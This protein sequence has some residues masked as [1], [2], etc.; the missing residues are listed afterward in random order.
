MTPKRL[1]VV[2]PV[3]LVALACGACSESTGP[4]TTGTPSDGGALFDGSF[5]GETFV[6]QRVEAPGPGGQLVPVDLIGTDVAVDATS[7]EVSISVAVR[8]RSD[9][10]LHA[11]GFVWIRALDPGTIEVVDPDR[12]ETG[13]EPPGPAYGYDYSA[14]LGGDEVL[15]PGEVSGA[16]RW[17]FGVPE[18]APFTFAASA[19]FALEP[20]HAVIAGRIFV[21]RDRDGEADPGE[22]PYPVGIVV[23]DGPNGEHTTA[24]PDPDRAAYHFPIDATGLYRLT[25]RRPNFPEFPLTTPNPLSVLITPGPDGEP[26]SI[27]DASFGV[28]VPVP[29][30]SLPAIELVDEPYAVEPQDPYMLLSIDVIG[31]VLRLEVGFSGCGADHPLV[32]YASTGWMES[33]P[34]QTWALLSHDDRGE[35]CDAW[36]VR[37]LD[38]DLRPLIA[39]YVDAFGEPGE[40]YLRFRDFEG[41]EHVVLVE[42]R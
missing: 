31:H 37:T 27:D 9:I 22:P 3:L 34:P 40:F 8:N 42:P 16:K 39:H 20:D 32:V 18:L 21:D 33:I 35:L 23:L 1:S 29:P 4:R 2:S 6:L 14:L 24:T 11:P 17:R 13:P 7:G 12:V 38:V 28:D 36:F 19:T 41:G 15:E 26:Q 5:D 30:D 10:A 25:Y